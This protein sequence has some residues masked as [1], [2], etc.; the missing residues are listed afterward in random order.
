MTEHLERIKSKIEKLKTLD[1]SFILFGSHKHKYQLNPTLSVDQIRQFE[2]IHHVTLP[3]DYADFL[4]TLGNG[5]VG[6][7]YGLEPLENALYADLDYKPTDYLLDPSKP[8]PHILG[9]NSEFESTVEEED[10]EEEYSNQ[11]TEFEELYFDNQHKT[12]SIAICNCGCA[13]SI[14]LVVNG[15]EYG[16][17]WTDDR[18]SYTGIYP[19]RELGNKDKIAFLNWYELW[20]DN[21]LNEIKYKQLSTDKQSEVELLNKPWWKLW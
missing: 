1:R 3:N 16:N 19:S 21:S 12:G 11:L 6:P 4:T 15:H 10:D 14:I 13:I 2:L 18:A 7:F 9:W 20:L 17:V 8:F 5:G